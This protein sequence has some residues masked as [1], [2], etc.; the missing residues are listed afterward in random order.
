M[1]GTPPAAP[2]TTADPDAKRA[3]E[4]G[5]DVL[6]LLV[7]NVQTGFGPFIANYLTTAAWTQT[8]IGLA[9]SIGNATAMASQIPAGALVDSLHNKTRV[10]ALSVLVY[11]AEILH[12]FS[13]CT[14]GP[15][16]AAMTLSIAGS[17]ALGERFGRNTR[18]ASIGNG[19]GAALMGA[20]NALISARA[21]FFL[22]AV[23]ALPILGSLRPLRRYAQMHPEAAPKKPAAK[24]RKPPLQ[25]MKSLAN[26]RL[27]AFCLGVMLFTF[28]N[29][30]LLPIVS[31]ELTLSTGSRAGWLIAGCIV[32]PQLIV[33]L[34]A[35]SMGKL[36]QQ[37]GRRPILA[38]GFV[39]V[40]L[41]AALFS[42]VSAPAAIV[43][44]QALDGLAAASFGVLLPLVV[45]DIAGRSGHFNLCLGTAG[46]AV[47][48]GGTLS[49][50]AAGWIADHAGMADSFR[51]LGFV[52][53][54]AVIVVL[55]IMPETAPKAGDSATS[56][57]A[58]S[59]GG[60]G[61]KRPPGAQGVAG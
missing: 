33:A 46:F 47:G 29:S 34:A 13:S 61:G 9:L 35:P 1:T 39:T 43:A 56:I 12:G 26:F 24:K 55:F 8:D 45:S 23:L 57:S 5:L 18:F 44:I 10:A 22:T 16:I 51:A 38:L 19:V 30:P 31:S 52:G 36:A 41:R 15:A 11:I 14:L 54:L 4:R 27:A 6:N 59:P 20:C 48:I 32:L 17:A 7:A 25:L 60:D 49:T 28:A 58:E 53:I 37:H 21:V 2:A 50:T 3:A 42:Y 40:P